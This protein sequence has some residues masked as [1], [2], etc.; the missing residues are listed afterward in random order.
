MGRLGTGFGQETLAQLY[1]KFQPLVRQN[2]PFADL[3]REKGVTYLAPRLVAQVAYEE[4][5]A[6]RKLRQLKLN[7]S[8]QVKQNEKTDKRKP[9]H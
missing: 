1:R 3:P 4:L 2:S 8:N 5:T 7:T 6:D 9:Y